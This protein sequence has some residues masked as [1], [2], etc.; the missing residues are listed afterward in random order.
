MD[1][2]AFLSSL[3]PADRAAL[4]E[5]A[6]GPGLRHL[7]LHLGLIAA[8]AAG[9]AIGVPLWP[10]LLPPLGIALAFLFTIEHECTHKTPFATPWL[11]EAV[12]HLAGFLILQ[13]FLWFRY[14]HL[15]HHRFTNDPERDPELL[16]KPKP[17]GWGE[18][19]WHLSSLKYWRG[20]V[21]LLLQNA[22]DEIQGDFVPDRARGELRL[23]ARIMLAFYAVVLASLAFSPLLLWIWLFPLAI[24]FP[25]LRLYLLAEHGRC[26]TVANMFVNTRT[27][28][29]NR[30]VRFLAWN[31]PFH[32]EHHVFPAVP[33]HRL[34]A[35][36]RLTA[37]HL[38]RTSPG[39][40]AFAREYVDG[41]GA[42]T[43][44]ETAA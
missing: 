30:L 31:M 40:R 15:A 6:D 9:V 18:F 39:Y 1:H 27:T 23:E 42:P 14:F 20:K 24:G 29:T 7:S 25:V 35:F 5:R 4:I 10:A 17:E 12:G 21:V 3:A 36:N 8:L 34:P 13:P 2:K 33:F 38:E 22:F 26:P 32:A 28:F 16:G 37:A 11:N 41:F 44:E 43:A 19:A